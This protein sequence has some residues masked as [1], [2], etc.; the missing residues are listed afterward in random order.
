MLEIYTPMA[1][2]LAEEALNSLALLIGTNT[3]H[4]AV[5]IAMT[6]GVTAMAYQYVMGAKIKSVMSFLVMSFAVTYILLGIK[7][8]VA[9]IDMQRP[10]V[11][12]VV[13][14]V[15]LG[16]AMPASFVSRIGRAISK[17]FDD[18]FHMPD[19]MSYNKTG[20]VFGNRIMLAASGANFGTSP[21]LSADLSAYMRQCIWIGRVQVAR[22]LTVTEIVNS[23]NLMSLLFTNPA[24]NYHVVLHDIGNVDCP[25]AAKHLLGQ[26]IAAARKE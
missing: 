8:P 2:G 16:V 24:V 10:M 7:F 11:S 12:H 9:I 21:D 6:M 17:T 18:V 25:T 13:D 22:N 3:F 4:S 15:P 14:D 19:E 26:L 23:K 5:N 1:G 20:M